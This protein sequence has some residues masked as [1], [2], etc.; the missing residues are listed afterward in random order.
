MP[1]RKHIE[2]VIMVIFNDLRI[3]AKTNLISNQKYIK[4]YEPEFY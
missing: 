1:K 4:N 3:Y 2:R